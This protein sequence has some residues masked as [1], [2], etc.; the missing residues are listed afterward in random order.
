MHNKEQKKYGIGSNVLFML[1]TA[2]EN[3]KSVVW[4]SLLL[5]LLKV[6]IDLAN[7]FLVPLIL[8]KVEM[9]AP[10]AELLTMTAI[11]AVSLLVMNCLVGY[12]EENLIY[13]RIE[14]RCAVVRKINHK[15]FN[16][17]YPNTKNPETLRLQTEAM[18]NCSSNNEPA[19]LVWGTLTELLINGIGFVVYLILLMQVPPALTAVVVGTSALGFFVSRRINRW[20][21]LHKEEKASYEKQLS[22]LIK[23]TESVKLAKDIRILGWHHG[24]TVY[25]H[26]RSARRRLLYPAGNLSIR[27]TVWW[28]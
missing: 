14:V 28:M 19:E 9:T 27:G 8:R 15:A 1:Q 4:L 23:K 22:Y 25:M 6:G 2:W 10:L 21:Y 11:F 18:N 20:E 13:G 7:L 3:A 24:S 26:Q 17:S 5:A 12:L 16:T